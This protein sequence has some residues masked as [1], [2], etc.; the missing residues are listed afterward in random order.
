MGIE[1]YVIQTK[2]GQQRITPCPA[3]FSREIMTVTPLLPACKS[4]HYKTRRVLRRRKQ[5]ESAENH[6][7]QP[8]ILQKYPKKINR[9]FCNQTLQHF[10]LETVACRQA[11]TEPVSAT[12]LAPVS[13][14]RV[15]LATPCA[16]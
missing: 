10:T 15:C 16:L 7:L 5:R 13:W 11:C 2:A 14:A 3:C 8:K 4:R 1:T 6:V 12:C 9:Y